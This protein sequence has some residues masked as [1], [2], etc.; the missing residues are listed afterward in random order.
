MPINSDPEI[1]Y[2][3]KEF[4]VDIN[5]SDKS[6]ENSINSKAI[7]DLSF[8]DIEIELI[9]RT[10]KKNAN[11]RRKTARILGISERTLY[12]KIKEYDLEKD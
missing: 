1:S 9:S 12:R 3:N 5:S 2:F 10:L 7:G 6:L 11:N 4:E 8:K